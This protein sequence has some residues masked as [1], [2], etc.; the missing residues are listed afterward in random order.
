MKKIFWI[1]SM[2]TKYK[3]NH[4][5]PSEANANAISKR[6][7]LLLQ[8]FIPQMKISNKKIARITKLSNKKLI[9]ARILKITKIKR[10]ILSFPPSSQKKISKCLVPKTVASAKA[11]R[12]PIQSPIFLKKQLTPK[13]KSRIWDSILNLSQLPLS[14]KIHY[15][16]FSHKYLSIFIENPN[17]RNVNNLKS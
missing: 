5:M 6:P 1:Q 2:S 9:N 14:Q 11:F 12:L 13:K 8:G 16:L 7:I 3:N 4:A 10:V 17:I 15:D